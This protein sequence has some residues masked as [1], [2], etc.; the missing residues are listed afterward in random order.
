MRS[1]TWFRQKFP[2]TQKRNQIFWSS[3]AISISWF[4][5]R[6]KNWMKMFCMWRIWL[7]PLRTISTA[8]FRKWRKNLSIKSTTKF[9]SYNKTNLW[10]LVGAGA[11]CGVSWKGKIWFKKRTK[12]SAAIR[13]RVGWLLSLIKKPPIRKNK[14]WKPSRPNF[15]NGYPPRQPV[16]GLREKSKLLLSKNPKTTWCKLMRIRYFWW[17]KTI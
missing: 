17:T 8:H 12:I 13:M 1:S 7:T 2:K 10:V 14:I 15:K 11:I 5:W 16:P 6:I 3:K 4:L 9:F